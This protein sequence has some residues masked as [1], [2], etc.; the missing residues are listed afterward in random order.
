MNNNIEVELKQDCEAIQIPAG[1]KTTIPA[2]TTGAPVFLA[3]IA[4]PRF[5]GNSV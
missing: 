1:L 3:S 4:T 2:G 5:I